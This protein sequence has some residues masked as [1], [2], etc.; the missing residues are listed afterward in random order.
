MK[1]AWSGIWSTI[2][3]ASSEPRS[4]CRLF[5]L[6]LFETLW[7]ILTQLPPSA[8]GSLGR[9]ISVKS[10]RSLVWSGAGAECRWVVHLDYADL[11]RSLSSASV[12]LESQS[13]VWIE[14]GRF[15]RF[16]TS[17]LLKFSQPT[18]GHFWPRNYQH[19]DF[20]FHLLLRA[21]NLHPPRLGLQLW[22]VRPPALLPMRVVMSRVALNEFSE[23]VRAPVCQVCLFVSRHF[24][25]AF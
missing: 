16:H 18:A 25:H 1:Q 15:L 9:L 13:Q 21:L 23:Y 2:C 6:W 5:S 19:R 14:L 8:V 24:H 10:T 17:L 11:R 3:F 7:E 4:H 22:F 20:E 12:K